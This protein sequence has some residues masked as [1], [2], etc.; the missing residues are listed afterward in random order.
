MLIKIMAIHEVLA[1]NFF[2]FNLKKNATLPSQIHLILS[3]NMMN[4][5]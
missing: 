1:K 3:Q 5:S 4:D 2:E